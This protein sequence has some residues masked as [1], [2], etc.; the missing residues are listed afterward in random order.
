MAS[1]RSNWQDSLN[2]DLVNRLTRPSRQPGMTKR[3]IDQGIIGRCDRFLNRLP[4]LSQQM[5]RWGNT[6][7]LSSESVPIIYAQPISPAQEAIKSQGHISQPTVS[8]NQVPLIQRK[9][10]TSQILAISNPTDLSSYN[11]GNETL[12][13]QN[14]E[15]PIN[16]SSISSS[17][18]PIVSPQSPELVTTGEM[19]L[20]PKFTD[21]KISSP[22]NIDTSLTS[23]SDA[24]INKNSTSSSENPIVSPQSPELVTTQEMPLQAKFADSKI[25]SSAN[26]DTSL[27]STSDAG[28]NTNST[29]SSEN[30]IVSSQSPELV[31]TQEMPLVQEYVSLADQLLPI[32]QAKSSD[33]SLSKSSVPIVNSLNIS[34]FPRQVQKNNINSENLT[35]PAYSTS[36][37][38]VT[39][40]LLSSKF[41]SLDSEISFSINSP[42][43]QNQS[44]STPISKSQLQQNISY[45]P[46]VSA[47]STINPNS[48]PQSSPLPLAK[49]SLSSPNTSYQPNQN[50][51]SSPTQTFTSSS[52]TTETSI[53]SMKNQSNTQSSI[54]VDSIASQVERKLMRRLVIES[55]RRGK[56]R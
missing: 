11:V 51:L 54:D 22:A 42:H 26:I 15:V 45:L 14:L 43:S 5:Q 39:Y 55:E 41:N 25:S 8:Q 34:T 46:I 18:N 6:N 32:I 12:Q 23:A 40:Q 20:Q 1:S 30:L 21:F 7:T 19:P 47:T 37:P 49:A 28:V 17:E 13:Y 33:S 24:G 52:P 16:Q 29:S 31:T 53:S 2:P 50:I 48:H 38:I 9:L 44:L 35:S 10:D 36:L 56:I 3:T 27:T 4:L